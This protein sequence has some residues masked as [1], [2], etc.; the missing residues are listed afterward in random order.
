MTVTDINDNYPRFKED[1]NFSLMEEQNFE[2]SE[3]AILS[4]VDDD[5]ASNGLPFTFELMCLDSNA[6]S[7][8]DMFSI[9]ENTGKL[10]PFHHT[11][12]L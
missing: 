4:A 12:A 10:N 6:S 5:I 11:D 8:C 2:S 1:Y 9:S 7:Q 3:I